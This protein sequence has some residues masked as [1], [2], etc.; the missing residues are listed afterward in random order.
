MPRP[1][2]FPERSWTPAGIGIGSNLNDPVAQ[3]RRA[4]AGLELL[5]STRL[6]AVSGLYRSPPMGPVDQPDYI[7][8]VAMILTRLGARELMEKLQ[9]IERQHGRDRAAGIRWGPRTLDLDILT[10]GFRQIDEPD[11]QIPHPGISERN[12]VLLPLCNIAPT[13]HV[14]DQGVVGVLAAQ[15]GD[16]GLQRINA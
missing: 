7:N 12:F 2:V 15:A 8:A 16:A 5:D 9:S 1:E 14:P 13:L 3:V 11:L 10:F 6:M 4:V